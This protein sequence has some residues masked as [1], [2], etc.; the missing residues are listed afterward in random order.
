VV[1]ELV[2]NAVRHAGGDLE[3]MIA[4]REHFLHV[5]V[6]DDSPDQPRRI[7]ADPGT[8]EGGRGLILLDAVATN[9]GSMPVPQG[10][11]VWATLRI[12]R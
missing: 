3:L 2:S 12:R 10:K 7:L 8:G 4:L 6:R 5:S 11:V 9:W 1:T